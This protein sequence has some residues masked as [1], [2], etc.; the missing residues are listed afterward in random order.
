MCED[1]QNRIDRS[2][3]KF[4]NANAVHL[5]SFSDIGQY[6]CPEKNQKLDRSNHK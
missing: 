5:Y 4:P 6:L 1:S 3:Y 2:R